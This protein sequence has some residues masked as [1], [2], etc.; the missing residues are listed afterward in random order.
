MCVLQDTLGANAIRDVVKI[1]IQAKFVIKAP[2]S[3]KAV[4]LVCMV[5]TVLNTVAVIVLIRHVQAIGRVRLGVKMGGLV[6]N[7]II[8]VVSLF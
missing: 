8:N 6:N 7:V 1:V 5:Q 4:K 3:V 2:D